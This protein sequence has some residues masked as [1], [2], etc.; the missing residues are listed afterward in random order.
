V[1]I[2]IDHQAFDRAT[3]LV[4]EIADGLRQEHQQVQADVSDLLSVGWNGVASDQF[5]QAWLKWCRGMDDILAGIGLQNALLGTVR[6]DLD[7]TDAS[8]HAAAQVLQSR[9]GEV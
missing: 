3:K 8:R 4:A 7:R 6:A 9:L 2:Q 1:T 5:G